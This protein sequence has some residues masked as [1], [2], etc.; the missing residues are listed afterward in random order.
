MSH[1][2]NVSVP[3]VRKV[4]SFSPMRTIVQ[5]KT[6]VKHGWRLSKAKVCAKWQQN[7]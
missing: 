6:A 3:E 5:G 7:Q 4:W 2:F 1:G